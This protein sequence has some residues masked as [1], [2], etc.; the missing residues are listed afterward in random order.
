MGLTALTEVAKP[1]GN[2]KINMDTLLLRAPGE[3]SKFGDRM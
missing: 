1:I 3:Y 2:K